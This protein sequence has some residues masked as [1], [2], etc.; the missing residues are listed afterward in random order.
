MA[1]FAFTSGPFL[2][3]RTLRILAAI[4]L[5]SQTLLC[6]V[7][8]RVTQLFAT[9]FDGTEL[10]PFVWSEKWLG[11]FIMRLTGGD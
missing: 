7:A 9:C 5:G 6:T 11:T 1:H 8:V 10:I 3:I 2:C 4:L